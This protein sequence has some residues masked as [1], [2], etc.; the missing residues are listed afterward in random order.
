MESQGAT[1]HPQHRHAL[2]VPESPLQLEGLQI[3]ANETMR[4]FPFAQGSSSVLLSPAHCTLQSE[5]ANQRRRASLGHRDFQHCDERATPRSKAALV[6]ATAMEPDQK[7]SHTGQGLWETKM[8]RRGT[9]GK[10]TER[11]Q[12]IK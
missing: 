3:P 9:G 7:K 2:P 6:S 11:E 1:P 4:P 8:E 12:K 10:N 5:S